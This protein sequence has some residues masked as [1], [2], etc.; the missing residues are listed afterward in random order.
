MLQQCRD[1][2]M[3]EKKRRALWKGK[4]GGGKRGRSTLL[5][6]SYVQSNKKKKLEREIY[7][8]YLPCSTTETSPECNVLLRQ[9]FHEA[10]DLHYGCKMH[11]C[12]KQQHGWLKELMAQNFFSI[13]IAE[14]LVWLKETLLQDENECLESVRF[15]RCYTMLKAFE[16]PL[17][18]FNI[19]ICIK[20]PSVPAMTTF[21]FH[22][23]SD[24]QSVAEAH[25]PLWQGQAPGRTITP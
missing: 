22:F 6:L 17:P 19:Q 3:R 20:R 2:E 24:V 18:C 7:I 25:M 23:V 1:G 12:R 10:R 16:L 14:I 5:G 11:S 4:A 8:L 9:K 15:N 21:P 13:S